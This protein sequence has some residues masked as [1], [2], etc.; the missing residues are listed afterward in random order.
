MPAFCLMS[1]TKSHLVPEPTPRAIPGKLALFEN[2]VLK[3]NL[4]I[5]IEITEE[6]Q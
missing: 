4:K 6:D 3:P 5:I 2:I 1:F